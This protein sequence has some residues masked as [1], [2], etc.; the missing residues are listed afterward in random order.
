MKRLSLRL[1]ML[2]CA[3]TLVLLAT[4]LCISAKSYD[5]SNGIVFSTDPIYRMSKGYSSF[6][7]TY[8]ATVCFPS[9]TTSTSGNNVIIGSTGYHTHAGVDFFVNTNGNPGL[10]YVNNTVSEVCTFSQ[11]NVFTGEE[12]NIAIV[13]DAANGTAS[14]YINGGLKQTVDFAAPTDDVFFYAPTVLGGNLDAYGT[15][16][17]NGKISSV[18]LYSDMRTEVEIASDITAPGKDG[19]I[20]GYDL[21]VASFGDAVISDISGNGFDMELCNIWIEEKEEVSDYA[22]SIAV[23]GDIQALSRYKPDNLHYIYDY[24]LENKDSKNI[25]FVAGLGDI[26]DTDATAEWE[27]A[28]PQIK[29]LDGILPYTF[30]RGNHD[31]VRKINWYF[32]TEDYIDTFDGF[33]KD[34]IQNS[35]FEF[36]VGDLRYLVLTLDYGAKD[37]ILEWANEIIDAYPDHNVIIT[38]HS[39]LHPDGTTNDAI[40]KETQPCA[41]PSANVGYNDGIDFWNKLINKHDNVTM[42]L[43]GHET[44]GD[45]LVVTQTVTD[46]GNVVTQML[47]DPQTSDPRYFND[48]GAGIVTMLYFS[49]DGKTVQVEHYSTIQQKYLLDVNQFTLDVHS[50]EREQPTTVITGS[51][52]SQSAAGDLVFELISGNDVVYSKTIAGNGE[53]IQEFEA[54]AVPAGEYDLIVSKTGHLGS[55]IKNV[56]IS[57]NVS[58]KKHNIELIAGNINGDHYIDSTDVAL[59]V[60]DMGKQASEASSPYTDIN[61]DGFRDALDV[62]VLSYN[63]LTPMPTAEYV[64][65]KIFEDQVADDGELEGD[66]TYTVSKCDAMG[67]AWGTNLELSDNKPS[68]GNGY[69]TAE[70]GSC[71]VICLPLRNVDLSGYKSGYFTFNVYIEDVSKMKNYLG[72]D[73]ADSAGNT[74]S[75]NSFS[76]DYFVS[77]WNKVTAYFSDAD[78]D[79]LDYTSVVRFRIFAYST[80][81]LKIGLDDVNVSVVPLE[82]Y[83]P[84]ENNI[85]EAP[86]IIVKVAPI[87]TLHTCETTTG[88]RGQGTL[89]VV[90]ENPIQGN[91]YLT[92]TDH[93]TPMFI[94][95]V[96]TADCSAYSEGT[97]AL[98]LYFDDVSLLTGNLTVQLRST[99]TAYKAQW[100]IDK[101]QL[102]SGWNHLVLSYDD[103]ASNNIDFTTVGTVRVFVNAST[104]LIMGIDNVKLA[105]PGVMTQPSDAPPKVL[106][107]CDAVGT[108]WGENLSSS[109]DNPPEGSGYLISKHSSCPVIVANFDDCDLTEYQYGYITCKVYIEDVSLIKDY[110]SFDIWDTSDKTT[111]W[112]LYTKD[113]TFKN[114]WNDI[115]LA[116]A[117]ADTVAADIT[118]ISHIRFFAYVNGETTIGIDDIK[119][120]AQ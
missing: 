86:E 31:S 76:K 27:A 67:G 2:I 56:R 38:T 37:E 62:T 20:L 30:V 18:A 94:L 51:V 70:D 88:V 43:C 85:A 54:P 14:C 75:I 79:A 97:F 26:T 102:A 112:F 89:A 12:V 103:A 101:T 22:F 96:S 120:Y 72:I 68:E 107:N 47:C 100:S 90:T 4:A 63:L 6:P 13:C 58:L 116:F 53:R 34:K 52:T 73:F 9:G 80:S 118:K 69:I 106:S 28:V 7:Y 49:E 35:W 29:R 48:G 40:D 91:G 21:D 24:I 115:V 119:I 82:T 57:G 23:V 108:S 87:L 74:V 59:F 19:L 66:P 95:P 111:K 104:D 41:P 77:G 105:L 10:D 50:V 60:N 42:V 84:V 83:I 78:K 46:N 61:A 93:T 113:Y 16:T 114:G 110:I 98:S 117:D 32:D 44:L 64:A 17:F 3:M 33:C 15:G 99:D 92:T 11:V 39:Y 81:Q 36:S 65:T 71:P 55:V 5:T 8:E 109:T 45:D 25:K 1:V